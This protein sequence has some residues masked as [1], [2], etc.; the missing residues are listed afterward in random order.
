MAILDT[1]VFIDLRGRTGKRYKAAA[2][3]ALADL[4]SRREPLLTTR[5]NIAE[6]YVGVHLSDDPVA[7]DAAVQAAFQSIQVLDFDDACAMEFGRIRAHLRQRG[8][9]AGDMDTLIA[10]IAVSFG[11]AVLTRNPAHFGNM[12]GLKVLSYG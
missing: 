5:I 12:P 1:T 8:L 3:A 4:V 10:A 7:E 2:E 11:E 6:L 9:P